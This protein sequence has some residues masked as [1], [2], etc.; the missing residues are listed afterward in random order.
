MT[1]ELGGVLV[2]HPVCQAHQLSHGGLP[3]QIRKGETIQVAPVDESLPIT[4]VLWHWASELP[5]D[6]QL[7]DPFAQPAL[8]KLMYRVPVQTSQ[9]I[10]L[11]A[12]KLQR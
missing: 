10:L 4:V 7:P 2:P 8:T 11:P 12:D 3:T 1:I 9:V 6:L 5:A